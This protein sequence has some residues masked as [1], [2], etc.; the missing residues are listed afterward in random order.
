MFRWK[1]PY[2]DWRLP[3]WYPLLVLLPGTVLF[4]ALT[5]GSPPR[6]VELS[7]GLVTVAMWRIAQV[8]VLLDGNRIKVRNMFG[9]RVLRWD[10]VADVRDG[11]D[12]GDGLRLAFV[13]RSGERVTTE[14]AGTTL[15]RHIGV[16]LTQ[17]QF[18]R[19]VARLRE[20]LVATS[21]I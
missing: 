13:L 8:G 14:V 12:L 7:V 2:R 17:R 16:Y 18:R 21:S 5:G 15:G 3:V 9:T 6:P 4:A 10:D 19:L 1:R 11:M 20:R